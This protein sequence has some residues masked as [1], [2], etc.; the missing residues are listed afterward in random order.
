[1]FDNENNITLIGFYSARFF[2][3]EENLIDL[4]SLSKVILYLYNHP[5]LIIE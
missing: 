4:K 5:P 1:M 2:D 3:N